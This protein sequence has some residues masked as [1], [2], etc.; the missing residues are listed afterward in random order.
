MIK[1]QQKDG[2]NVTGICNSFKVWHWKRAIYDKDEVVSRSVKVFGKL[3]PEIVNIQLDHFVDMREKINEEKVKALF[4]EVKERFKIR[5]I[6]D[7]DIHKSA[8]LAITMKS[9]KS[10]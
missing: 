4:D 1:N 2:V 3:G 7:N 8:R 9:I 10:I 6:D 5:D